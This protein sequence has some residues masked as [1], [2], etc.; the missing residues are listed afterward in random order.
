MSRAGCPLLV[1]ASWLLPVSSAAAGESWVKLPAQDLAGL[2]PAVAAQLQSLDASTRQQLEEETATLETQAEAVG[3]LGRHYH[4]YE[5]TEAAE[6]CYR[7]A[8]RLSPEDFRWPYFL[9]YLLQSAGR[10]DEAQTEYLEALALYRQVPPAL[11]R[12]GEVY[13]DLGQPEA[14]EKLFKEALSLDSTSAAIQAALG[15]LYAA[16]GRHE[17]AIRAL[18]MAL[19]QEPE[20]TRLYYPLAMAYRGRG[21]LVRAKELL[22]RRGPIGIKPADPLIDGLAELKTGE[23][24][25]LLEGQAAFRAGRYEEA[26][27]SFRKAVSAAPESVTARIDLGSA[28][29]EV[30]NIEAALAEYDQALEIAP[31]NPTA[32]FN[33]G[34]LRARRGELEVALEHLRFAAQIAPE[35]VTIRLWLADVLA[36]VGDPETA[37]IHYRAAVEL[38]PSE[39][40]ARLGEAQALASLGRFAEAR[41]A[42]EQGLIQLPTSGLL[43]HG[44]SRLLAMGPDLSIR[45][46]ERALQLAEKVL[47]AQPTPAH[48]E[49]VAAAL[50]DLGRCGEAL[51]LQRQVVE[52]SSSEELATRRQEVLAIYAQGPPCAYPVK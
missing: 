20:A 14:A 6:S 39:E 43:A 32:R 23:R 33:A 15:E 37:L 50:A 31:A 45:N 46:G 44:L 38:E 1:I 41:D 7:V 52:E 48:A 36:M 40:A 22:A 10:L 4:A 49:V 13:R 27:A 51:E 28:L 9:G 8:R 24:A 21:E 18:E 35:D 16:Q 3:D 25:Y 11:L 19:D 2:E 5:L 26:V 29:G 30:G 42:L 47:A 34:L 12:L 17:E